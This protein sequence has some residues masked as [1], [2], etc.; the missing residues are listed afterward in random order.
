MYSNVWSE[1]LLPLSQDDSTQPKHRLQPLWGLTVRQVQFSY[2]QLN[3]IPLAFPLD[4]PSPIRWDAWEKKVRLWSSRTNVFPYW[5]RERDHAWSL[6]HNPQ[7]C[8]TAI[9]IFYPLFLLDCNIALILITI[10]SWLMRLCSEVLCRNCTK[11]LSPVEVKILSISC[12]IWVSS[13]IHLSKK[14]ETYSLE[15][16]A[17]KKNKR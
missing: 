11:I 6:V 17:F 13:Q 16:T 14:L 4:H 8:G 3:A 12:G 5:L 9:I 7:P 10:Q 2:T 15:N 1:C